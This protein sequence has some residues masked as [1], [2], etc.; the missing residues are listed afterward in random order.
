MMDNNDK[1]WGKLRKTCRNI[2]KTGGFNGK[3]QE[4]VEKQEGKRGKTSDFNEKIWKMRKIR[5]KNVK[6]LE[7][8]VKFITKRWKN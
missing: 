4:N 7:I 3:M 6:K 2:W 8:L 1:K 5:R